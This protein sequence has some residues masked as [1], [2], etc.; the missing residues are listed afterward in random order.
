[1]LEKLTEIPKKKLKRLTAVSFAGFIL[2]HLLMVFT[3]SLPVPQYNIID[4]EF[5]RTAHQADTIM[6]TWGEAVVKQEILVTYLD[7]GYLAAYGM[8]AFGLIL[9]AARAVKD[10]ERFKKMG[11][12]VCLFPLIA[13]LCDAVENVNL[14]LMLYG[15]PAGASSFN[16]FTAYLFAFLKFGL[17]AVALGFFLVQLGYLLIKR[18]KKEIP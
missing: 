15:F 7:Y 14:L 12:I 18:I 3:R 13:A 5:A 4:F 11:L 16:A 9:L 2:I 17:L 6:N 8:A 1:M 10:N